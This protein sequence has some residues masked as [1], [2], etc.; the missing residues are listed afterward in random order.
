M[1][2]MKKE[3]LANAG[4]NAITTGSNATTNATSTDVYIYGVES[5]AILA[6]G[7]CIFLHL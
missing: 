6:V 7:L 4:T 1:L 3:I 2:K 5:L